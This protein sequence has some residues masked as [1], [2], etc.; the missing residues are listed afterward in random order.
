MIP[1]AMLLFSCM[2]LVQ[3]FMS[4]CRSLLASYAEVELSS[5]T[6]EIIG[7]ESTEIGGQ[8]FHRLLGLVRLAPNPGDDKWDLR[9]I[10]TYYRVVRLAGMVTSPLS[11]VARK[12]SER[13][14]SMCA[15]FA[16]AAL[17]RRIASVTAG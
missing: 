6:R 17:S 2:A 9:I 3:F 14:S 16:A 10:S 15:Y 11:S 4:Y 5:A 12:W 1:V 8:E 13:Q 7:M